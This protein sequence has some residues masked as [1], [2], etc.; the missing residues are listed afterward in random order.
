MH[1]AA[2]LGPGS[3]EKDLRPF[4]ENSS[5]TWLIG[6]PATGTDADIILILGGD[7]TVHH[8]LA[9]LVKLGLPVLVV[10]FGSG[11]DFARALEL[12][13]VRDSQAAF[14]NF[15]GG[16]GKVR[17]IDLGLIAG[18]GSTA[19]GD[20][21]PTLGAAHYFCCAAGAGLDAAVARRANLLPRWLRGN[22][23][24][25]LSLLA[26][27]VP[28]KARS[29]KVWIPDSTS[30]SKLINHSERP[31]VLA[32]IANAQA[33]G[34]GMRIA[35]AAKLDDGQLDVCLVADINK[36]KLLC[37]FPTVYFGRHLQW[38]EVEH[39]QTSRLRLDTENPTDVY[40]DGEYVCQTPV[41]VSIAPRALQVLT[42]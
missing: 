36:L 7:G 14:R 42:L 12:R 8:H 4:Q 33:Y 3:S 16:G 38:A 5:A 25:A 13:S 37:L 10:P 9:Q 6:M 23:G 40:A 20:G 2:V 31:T 26:A 32:A 19:E 30:P 28:F 24:Y 1:A 35:P 39:F 17:R 34:G 21:S 15:S 22:G 41:E 11:N 27:L 18:L 29:M